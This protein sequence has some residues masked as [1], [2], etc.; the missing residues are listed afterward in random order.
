MSTTSIDPPLVYYHVIFTLKKQ[1]EPLKY[2]DIISI[3][4]PFFGDQLILGN[5]SAYMPETSIL[6]ASDA[7][8]EKLNNRNS[9]ASWFDYAN[10]HSV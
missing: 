7:Y 9:I 4:D 5:I 10:T 2:V 1:G 8:H 6:Y 3:H